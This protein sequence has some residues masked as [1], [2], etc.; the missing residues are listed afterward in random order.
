M[1]GQM[2]SELGGAVRCGGELLAGCTGGPGRASVPPPARTRPPA[3]RAARRP[4]ALPRPQ[5]RSFTFVL[6]TPPASVLLKKAAGIET[7]S[8]EPNRKKV[9]QVTMEQVKVKPGRGC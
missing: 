1:C 5:D 6:K 8:G 7:G 4:P 9:G 2:G 3:R